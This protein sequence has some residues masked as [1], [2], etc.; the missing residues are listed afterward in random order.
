MRSHL[1]VKVVSMSMEMT[2]IRRQ[3]AKWKN[4]ARYARQKQKELLI[5]P[6]VYER[7]ST[8]QAYAER[9]FWSNHHHRYG[10]KTEARVAHL[11]YGCMRGIPYQKMEY[12]CHGWQ[13]G[14]GGYEPDWK[15]VAVMVER[16]SKDEPNSQ[17]IMQKFEEWLSDAKVWYEG[18]EARSR[19]MKAEREAAWA[20]APPKPPYVRTA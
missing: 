5:Q 11:A 18:N 9:N 14:H 1:K 19:D 15:S 17:D 4:K 8:S 12:Y 2:Y 3:E 20:A 16:F 13:K 7:A 6:E 10:L